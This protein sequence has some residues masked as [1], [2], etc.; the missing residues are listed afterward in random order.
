MSANHTPGALLT[1][2]DMQVV[3]HLLP[4]YVVMHGLP[5]SKVVPPSH[6]QRMLGEL[7]LCTRGA[8]EGVQQDVS[9]EEI[10][11][12]PDPQSCNI[13]PWRS[14]TSW[15]ASDLWCEG[16]PFEPCCRNILGRVLINA[17]SM[18]YGVNAGI[19]G[20]FFV[21]QNEAG[22]GFQP[23][24]KCGNQAKP[25]YDVARLIENLP[26]LG[27]LVD[28]M[29]KLGWGVYSFDHTGGIGQFEIYF[30]Y[31]G[32]RSVADCM[33]FLPL[34]AYEIARRHG[35]FASF[36]TK[37]Y[38]DRA[39]SGA[40]FNIFLFDLK[41]KRNLIESRDDPRGCSLSGLG[42]HFIADVLKHRPAICAV[43]APTDNSYKL[44]VPK[45][46][47]PGVTWASIF[48]SNGSNNRTNTVM[49]PLGG[50]RVELRFPDA[51]CN[52]Y[53]G[54]AM[55]IAAMLEG[56][57]EQFD[58]LSPTWRTC[59]SRPSRSST[60]SACRA[61]HRHLGRPLMRSRLIR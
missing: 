40:H 21:L 53:L 24:N 45:G 56:V 57:R 35:K 16:K 2:L 14:D 48:V 23:F 31:F 39:G 38:A 33:V 7:A 58:Q 22:G 54:L 47:M 52:S 11:A 59:T 60:P 1:A 36:M 26:W 6:Y 3:K 50:G 61:F 8:M 5:I 13:L 10:S 49:I 27:E 15:Y 9:D 29:N 37:P 46:A 55:T 17:A 42:Y 18:G 28:A 51:V 19:E 4:T 32:A 30:K 43:V 34:M 12:R 41:S 44:L 25:A 20:E